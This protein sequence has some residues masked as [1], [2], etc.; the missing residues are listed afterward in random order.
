MA[1]GSGTRFWP[2]SRSMLPKQFLTILGSETM[3]ELTMKR[4]RPLCADN[5]IIIVGSE[6]HHELLTR[7]G[8][9]SQTVIFEEPRG[10]NTAPC[11][12][13]AAAY[14]RETGSADTPMIVL[15]ADHYIAD[16]DGFRAV[17]LAGC[18]LARQGDIVTI[19][20]LPTRPETGYGYLH[21]GPVRET[22][23]GFPV[24]QVRRFV[25]KPGLTDALQYLD[26]G[27]FFW[28][29]GIFIFSA[30]TILDEMQIHLPSVY[31]E[32]LHVEHS[33]GTDQFPAALRA[34]YDTFPSVS[35]DYGI[36]EKTRRSVVTLPGD[37]GWSDV[38]SW[39]SLY[40]VRKK[41][42]D[43]DGNVAIGDSILLDTS[44]SFVMNQTNH[45]VVALGL[46]NT[47]IV[48]TNDALFVADM[49]KSQDV[50][51]VIKELEERKLR[52]LL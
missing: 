25:E 19:G 38:G 6:E 3:L 27:E 8:A 30:R 47:I 9:G 4:V 46:Q 14:L 40:E 15:P 13:L 22:V 42:S 2:A 12:G 24:Y 29:G 5:R 49:K 16:E 37:F 23:A 51:R 7:Y 43:A 52:S 21:R 36:M 11:I 48:N 28:N 20:L 45:I 44:S 35:I 31:N 34:A 17:I 50:K 33:L 26:S 32:L 39:E 18:E 10:R 41:E 1:G